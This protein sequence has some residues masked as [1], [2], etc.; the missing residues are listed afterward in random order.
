MFES[1]V[2]L[3]TYGKFIRW[4]NLSSTFSWKSIIS[5]K[6]LLLSIAKTY[7]S[8]S[9]YEDSLYKEYSCVKTGF[10]VN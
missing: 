7:F 8:I 4:N 6:S 10:N 5:L 3:K 1:L 9:L 2:S